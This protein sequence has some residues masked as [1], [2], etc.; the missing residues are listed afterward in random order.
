MSDFA[1]LSLADLA[2]VDVSQ[3]EETRF[4]ALPMGAYEFEIVQAEV[5]EST[6]RDNEKVFKVTVENKIVNTIS[7]LK[8]PAGEDKSEYMDKQVGRTITERFTINVEKPQEDIVKAIGRVK[9]FFTDVGGTD[10]GANL[11]ENVE[12]LVGLTFNGSVTHQSDKDDKT[13][14]YARLKATPAKN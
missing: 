13:I 6:N 4:E 14:K 5:E 8:V 12:A 1:Q 7:I 9:S 3:I 11:I 10:W 2:G